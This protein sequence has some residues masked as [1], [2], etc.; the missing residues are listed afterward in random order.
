ML[1]ENQE[2]YTAKN[3]AKLDLSHMVIAVVDKGNERNETYIPFEDFTAD[4][5]TVPANGAIL[6]ASHNGKSI[7]V[8][9]NG[10]FAYTKEAL[11]V[12]T[13]NTLYVPVYDELE[14]AVGDFISTKIKFLDKKSTITPRPEAKKN[15]Q[16]IK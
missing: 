9:Y 11:I 2:N 15:L 6:D 5:T 7:K 10:N 4:I 14:K 3:Q 8:M 13:E 16:L 12:E 1:R